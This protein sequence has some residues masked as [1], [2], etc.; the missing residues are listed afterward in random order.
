MWGV[1]VEVLA[2]FDCISTEAWI[3]AAPNTWRSLAIEPGMHESRTA[4]Y[5]ARLKHYQEKKPYRDK[6]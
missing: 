4:D 3:G 6:K 1:C 5:R 2:V